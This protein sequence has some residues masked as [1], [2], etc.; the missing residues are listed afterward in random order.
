MDEASILPATVVISTANRSESIATT[1]QAILLNDYPNFE[2]IVVDQSEDHQT[3]DFLQQLSGS[4]RLRYI[5]TTVKG[6]SAG[7][8]IGISNAQSEFIAI[9]DDDCE[10]P[11]NW[12]REMVAAF[13]VDTRIGIVFGNVLPRPHDR[14]SVFIPA[15]VRREPF[16][17]RSMAQKHLVEGMS[18]CMGV[19]RSVWERLGGFDEMLGAGA[20]LKSGAE[21]DFTIRAL[22]S[23]YFVYE[24]PRVALIHN[25]FRTWQQGRILVHRYWYG[26]GAAMAKH[27]K[28]GEGSIV[29]LL[30]RLAWRWAFG[31]SLVATSLGTRPYRL[32]RLASFIQ[33]FGF[34]TL[35]PL[36]RSTGHYVHG[37]RES[38]VD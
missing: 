35:T 11:P 21:I 6:V 26:A 34:G 4:P 27:L 8:N 19:R 36:D 31:L 17:A 38:V 23:G 25:G 15:Y 32:L 14:A 29:R 33:G 3:M 7:R 24:T 1:V 9:T 2:L 5:R 22:L 13:S 18:A 16:L 10:A 37:R 12:L 28:F 30:P 20:P